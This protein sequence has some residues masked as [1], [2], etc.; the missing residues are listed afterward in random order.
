MKMNFIIPIIVSIL[1]GAFC[2]KL[3]FS[4]YQNNEEVF[5]ENNTIYVLQQGVYTKE[6]TKINAMQNLPC[7]ISVL[8]DGKYYVYVA[9]TKNQQNLEKVSKLFQEKKIDIYQKEIA[10]TN[11][12]FLNTLEQ[13]DL[14]LENA[15]TE[16]EM[17]SVIKVILASYEE[18]VLMS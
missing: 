17:I 8:D 12:E 13:Y 15:K 6:E 18:S 5:N 16:E 11:R 2:G 3:V 9:M 10:V 14:L 7:A 1:L 4:Q